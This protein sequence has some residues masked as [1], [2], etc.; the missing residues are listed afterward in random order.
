MLPSDEAVRLGYGVEANRHGGCELI[1]GF[2]LSALPAKSFLLEMYAF[3]STV[4]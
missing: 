2:P 3:W 1:S 4:G